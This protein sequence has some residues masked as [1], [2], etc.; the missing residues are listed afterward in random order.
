MLHLPA[1]CRGVLCLTLMPRD[2]AW[3]ISEENVEVVR[4]T[5]TPSGTGQLTDHETG[6]E[7]GHPVVVVV[8][9]TVLTPVVV[10][11]VVVSVVVVVVVTVSGALFV[12]TVFA[13]FF[14][15]PPSLFPE[16]WLPTK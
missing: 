4:R 3:T 14:P 5:C 15:V 2:T 12:V 8:I 11:T 16:G 7:S 6:R 13:A 9:V 10:V 1:S